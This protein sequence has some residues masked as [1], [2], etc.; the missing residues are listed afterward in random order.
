MLIKN[1]NQKRILFADSGKDSWN[2]P[3]VAR[4]ILRRVSKQERITINRFDLE[5][6][7]QMAIVLRIGGRF[8]NPFQSGIWTQEMEIETSILLK[9]FR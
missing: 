4:A 2:A 7:N 6:L 9:P 8:N 1:L 3:I 5:V